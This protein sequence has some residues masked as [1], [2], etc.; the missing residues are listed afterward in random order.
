MQMIFAIKQTKKKHRERTQNS[1]D[2]QKI[3]SPNCFFSKAALLKKAQ[4]KNV[5]SK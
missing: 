1:L 3:N 5:L 4:G 2:K